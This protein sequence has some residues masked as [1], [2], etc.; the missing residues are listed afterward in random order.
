MRE[1]FYRD[2]LFSSIIVFEGVWQFDSARFAGFFSANNDRAW[3]DAYYDVEIDA[4][5]KGE[6]EDLVEY[7][8]KNELIEHI[9][10][11]FLG[12]V[13]REGRGKDAKPREI[14]FS[15]GAPEYGEISNLIALHL[16]DWR[17]LVNFLYSRLRKDKAS[18]IKNK[19]VPIERNF[20]L[21][22]LKEHKIVETAFRRLRE[23]ASLIEQVGKSVTYIAKERNSFNRFYQRFKEEV[24][25]RATEEL[26]EANT[27]KR[28]IKNG[29]ERMKPLI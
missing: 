28:Q 4:Y 1:V 16:R 9:S 27:L 15:I 23:E 26:P 22:S 5:G 25:K 21:S 13:R 8:W 12:E 24:F 17:D 3:R 14:Y 19:V 20:F 6:Y 18:W 11:K 7:L 2:E 29:L 10:P